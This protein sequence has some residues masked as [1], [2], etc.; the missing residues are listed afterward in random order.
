MSVKY[1]EYLNRLEKLWQLI[2]ED[3]EYLRKQNSVIDRRLNELGKRG[4]IEATAKEMMEL[5]SQRAIVKDE[6]LMLLPLRDFFKNGYDEVQE[7][8]GRLESYRE[9]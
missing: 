7:R 9:T 1:Q 3:F 5:L 8:I 2:E 4:N 6:V